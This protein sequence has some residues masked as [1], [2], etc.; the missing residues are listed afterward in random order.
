MRQAIDPKVIGNNIKKLRLASKMSQQELAHKLKI[1]KA[2]VSNY[3]QGIRAP[4]YEIL[5][6]IADLFRVTTDS[7]LYGVSIS[8][9]EFSRLLQQKD[10]TTIEKLTDNMLDI[11]TLGLIDDDEAFEDEPIDT[12]IWD[13]CELMILS[14]LI[15]KEVPIEE[16]DSLHDYFPQVFNLII[17]SVIDKPDNELILSQLY[18]IYT[19]SDF[20]VPRTTIESHMR[21]L[22]L[23]T[24][25]SHEELYYPVIDYI[26]NNA[27]RKINELSM[28]HTII[29]RDKAHSELSSYIKYSEKA[30]ILSDLEKIRDKVETIANEKGINYLRN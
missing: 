4:K 9:D 26:L 24:A 13:L 17:D 22:L 3:E 23:D 1:T 27:K 14:P 21:Y 7:L 28:S 19:Y 20:P 8:L 5:V 10:K 30:S 18:S 25:K 2:G 11:L 16:I 29:K 12:E 6:R 15:K